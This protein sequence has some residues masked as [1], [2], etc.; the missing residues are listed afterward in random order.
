M[1]I[2]RRDPLGVFANLLRD[3]LGVDVVLKGRQLLIDYGSTPKVIQLPSLEQ[4]RDKDI[5]PLCGFC[6]HEAGHLRYTNPLV[7][8]NVPDYVV[9]FPYN[10]IEDEM[11][12]RKLE[13]DFPNAR[14]LL[15][16]SYRDGHALVTEQ[17][18]ALLPPRDKS[19]LDNRDGVVERMLTCGLD[20]SDLALV[21][22]TARRLEIERVSALW[23]FEKRGYSFL[24]LHDWPGHPWRAIFEEETR[25]P[26]HNSEQ[27][28]QQAARIR[29][30]I[31]LKAI[32]SEDIRPVEEARAAIAEA[33][34]RARTRGEA[35]DAFDEA[36]R[37]CNEEIRQVQLDCMEH[38]ALQEAKDVRIETEHAKNAASKALLQVR[39]RLHRLEEAEG[40]TQKRLVSR[41]KRVREMEAK[42]RTIRE[43]KPANPVE[44][45]E[46]SEAIDRCRYN[47]ELDDSIMLRRGEIIKK[48][49]EIEE[50]ALDA[51]LKARTVFL[52]K[53]D[54]EAKAQVKFDE[55]CKAIKENVQAKHSVFIGPLEKQLAERTKEA[56]EAEGVARD[57]LGRISRR[58]GEVEAP[59]GAP[60]ALEL[61]INH[62]FDEFKGEAVSEEVGGEVSTELVPEE[63]RKY[64]PYT[65]SNDV[66]ERVEETPEG[67]AKYEEA[68]DGVRKVIRPTA[69]NLR[70]LY[71]PMKHK[72]RTNVTAGR[73]D[74]RC[75]FKIG[76][77]LAGANV[78]VS[79][80]WRRIDLTRDPK[81]AISIMLDCS[82]SMDKRTG[83][84]G[85]SYMDLARDAAVAISEV[86]KELNIPHEILGHT[87]K[88]EDLQRKAVVEIAANDDGSQTLQVDGEVAAIKRGDSMTPV[89][90]FS[91]Y[92]PFRG[93]VFKPFEEKVPPA[94][95]YTKFPKQDNLDGEAI[96]WAAKRLEQRK[97]R[98]KI[99]IVLTDSMPDANLSN[100]AELR[101]HLLTI[102]RQVEA[103]E[104]EGLFLFG[105]G[106]DEKVGD[107]F[108]HSS[109]LDKIE[110]LPK[111][112]LGVV[113]HVLVRLVGTM[114]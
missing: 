77:V 23:F 8:E 57:I 25:E 83:G 64:C 80:I 84:A 16:S 70:R 76:L 42:L 29:E 31:G 108:A 99:L 65:R 81:V 104:R 41:L 100:K 14:E 10:A 95:L 9:K 106:M 46:L 12:E 3:Q 66:L 43:L 55:E 24:P 21:E 54:K 78:D 69:D 36:V 72:L 101:R 61:I 26:A 85:K 13:G 98:T 44:E 27:A 86:C 6:L 63:A 96:L 49:K 91:R 50:A 110:S 113:E 109:I 60:G 11:V 87:T 1:E 5:G 58:D 105:V 22:E 68:R 39:E 53:I 35:Q 114:G 2:F 18:P 47:I 19:W 74:P 20:P 17:Q 33:Q 75:A 56:E 30:R 37:A 34:A 4:G 51:S 40:K 111:T 73:L 67:R 62:V 92:V 97:E 45:A 90:N 38:E 7:L 107:Y 103:R 88:T 28:F 48:L 82:G 79:R 102:C 89:G 94:S 71:S 112:M 32:F 93:Y 15:E 52:D 59:F